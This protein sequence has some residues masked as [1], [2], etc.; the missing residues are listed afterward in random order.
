[1]NDKLFTPRSSIAER[2]GFEPP[3]P[4]QVNTLSRRAPST[5]RPSLLCISGEK[6]LPAGGKTTKR[7]MRWIL[8]Q[9]GPSFLAPSQHPEFV[10]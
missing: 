4:F 3:L 7:K 1:M 2:E 5:T 10:P 9:K 8:L 6:Y